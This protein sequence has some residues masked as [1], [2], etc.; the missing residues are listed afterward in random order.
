M[1]SSRPSPIAFFP[2]WGVKTG[3]YRGVDGQCSAVNFLGA[4]G[5]NGGT[6]CPYAGPQPIGGCIGFFNGFFGGFK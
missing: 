5:Y 2:K 3:V 1:P 4:F 6:F